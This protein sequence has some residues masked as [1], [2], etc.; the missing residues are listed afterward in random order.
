MDLYVQAYFDSIPEV[1]FN[2]FKEG[3]DAV[4]SGSI[5]DIFRPEELVELIVG[6]PSLDFKE[7]EEHTSYDGFDKESQ[8]IKFVFF[9]FFYKKN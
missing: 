1:P 9:C 2:A 8:T 4:L 7:L 5:I 3:F 6:S